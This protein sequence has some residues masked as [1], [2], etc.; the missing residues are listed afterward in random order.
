MLGK[1]FVFTNSFSRSKRDRD[2]YWLL[3]AGITLYR[4]DFTGTQIYFH[5]FR[6]FP[7]IMHVS[8]QYGLPGAMK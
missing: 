2:T 1:V 6:T 5:I 8:G 7:V 3:V 4:L